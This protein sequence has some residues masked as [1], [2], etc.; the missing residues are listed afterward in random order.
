MQRS[1]T[2]LNAFTQNE[3]SVGEFLRQEGV[4][5]NAAFFGP[6]TSKSQN[7]LHLGNTGLCCGLSRVALSAFGTRRLIHCWDSVAKNIRGCTVP[8]E[9]ITFDTSVVL[10]HHIIYNLH[11]R[12]VH[13][14]ERNLSG[15]RRQRLA[16]TQ[17][18]LSMVMTQGLRMRCAHG[19]TER[20]GSCTRIVNRAE[21]GKQ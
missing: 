15:A 20:L 7:F 17:H 9:V 18:G 11:D 5:A 2:P 1:C 6:Q 13:V 10:F 14:S 12:R 8:L 21:Q 16:D 4:H 19:S 3:E